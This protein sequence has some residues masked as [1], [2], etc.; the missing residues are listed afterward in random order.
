VPD[1]AVI[2]TPAPLPA[3]TAEAV[4]ALPGC[5][6]VDRVY[7]ARARIGRTLALVLARDFPRSRPAPLLLLEG[8]PGDARRGLAAGDVVL[9]SPLARRLG[10]GVG[11]E[12]EFQG[13]RGPVRFRVAGIAT[14]FSVGG[15]VALMEWESA[16]GL[17]G[18]RA[19]HA[20]AVW[21]AP[22][23]EKELA[24]SLAT[25]GRRESLVVQR[26]EDFE[27]TID[28]VVVGVRALVIGLVALVCLVAGLGV[29]NTLTTNVLDQTRELGVLRALGMKRSGVSKLVLCQAALLAFVSAVPGALA[30]I[31][32]AYL[33]NRNA[34]A[35]NGFVVD[36]QVEGAFTAGCL[37]GVVVLAGLSALIPARRAARLAVARA[38]QYE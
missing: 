19:P 3:G 32:L 5:G 31:G 16:R 18:F 15:M 35:L 12:V 26:N 7:F 29:V 34:P 1:P 2:L 14:E 23:Q 4:R 21:A 13:R 10:A 25:Y 9:G 17:L 28:R 8:D 27:A 37:A 38:L 33:M 24:R 11:D 6:E 22:G 20:L 36:F 30:G